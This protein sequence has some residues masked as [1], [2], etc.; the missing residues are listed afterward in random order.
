MKHIPQ[1]LQ[2][3]RESFL[4]WQRDVGLTDEALQA[5]LAI[6]EGLAPLPYWSTKIMLQKSPVEGLGVF[7]TETIHPFEVI[8]PVRLWSPDLQLWQRTI[9]GRY[10]NHSANRANVAFSPIPSTSELLMV[11]RRRIE[12]G[13]ELLMDYY[14]IQ[15]AYGLDKPT[16]EDTMT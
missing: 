14:Q 10:T 13:E 6:P 4:Q 1:F 8:A 15:Q 3:D 11:S 7:C 9:T 12:K 5:L 16:M 2:E